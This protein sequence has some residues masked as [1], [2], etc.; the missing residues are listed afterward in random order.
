[1][2]YGKN[3]VE[4]K[5]RLEYRRLG[6]KPV[7]SGWPDYLFFRNTPEDGVQLMAVEVKSKKNGL[8]FEQWQMLS[9][10]STVMRVVV[11][12]EHADGSIHE[13]TFDPKRQLYGR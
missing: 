3:E 4:R 12:K 9:L 5:T 10:L 7:R 13:Y 11:A 6:W 2:S 8:S 1:M